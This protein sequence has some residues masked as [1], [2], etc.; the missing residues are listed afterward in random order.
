MPSTQAALWTWLRGE[1]RGDILRRWRSVEAA[2]QPVFGAVSVIDAFVHDGGRD[3]SGYED[4]TENPQGERATE[5]AIVG[6]GG[7][8]PAGSSFVAVQRWLHD[9]ARLDAM[10]KQ[11]RDAAIGR[12]RESNEELADAPASAHVRR[13]AQE[14]FEPEAFVL[15]RS[16][17]WSG[18]EGAGLVFVAFGSSL[19]PFERQLLRMAGL[20][21]GI[22]D[23]LFA[24]TRPVS[25]AYYWCPPVAGGR[26]ALPR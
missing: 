19:D 4:G 16:M 21:D 20:D 13:T 26:I 24:F 10:T 15:R 5:V 3:L 6:E 22:V 1:D 23:G 17:P 11:A 18:P 25:G 12:E 7:D 8:A 9:F 14:G 2:L